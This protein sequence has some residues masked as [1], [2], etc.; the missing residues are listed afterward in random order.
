M[1]V[2]RCMHRLLVCDGH[3][4]IVHRTRGRPHAEQAPQPK[5]KH[6]L[7]P[8]HEPMSNL[9]HDERQNGG[10]KVER[11]RPNHHFARRAP[12]PALTSVEVLLK[13]EQKA[14]PC[15]YPASKYA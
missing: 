14:P 2:P 13:P 1:I 8:G 12:A 7:C 9:M 15:T 10:K 5:W 3:G 11:P 6:S 4:G